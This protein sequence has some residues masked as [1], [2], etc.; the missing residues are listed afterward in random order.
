[1]SMIPVTMQEICSVS[2]AILERRAKWRV[3]PAQG[4]A[5]E[6]EGMKPKSIRA[7]CIVLAVMEK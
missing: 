5:P 7:E 3:F 1:M 4:A 2:L 6:L